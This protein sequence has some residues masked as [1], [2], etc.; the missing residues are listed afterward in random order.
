[1]LLPVPTVAES[2]YKFEYAS[3]MD[4]QNRGVDVSL[5]YTMPRSTGGF[6]WNSAFNIAYNT[7]ELKKLP[8]QLDAIVVGKNKLQVGER[9]DQY[10]LL[11][12]RGSYQSD[13]E[14]PVRD[15][16]NK[17]MTYNGTDMK[18]GDPRWVDQ[19]GN[20]DINNE[21]RILMGNIIPKWTGGFTN[22]FA[23]KNFDLS[24]LLYFNLGREIINQQASKKYDFANV[25]E[26]K[27]LYGVREITSWEKSFDETAYPIYNPWSSVVPYQAEQDLF[28]ED[29][30]FVKLKNLSVGY[31]LTKVVNNKKLNR[32]YVYVTG[33][34]LLTIT[35]Y[36]GRDPELVN[37][38]GY[39]TGTGIRYP[40]MYTLGVKLDF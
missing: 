15:G 13:A 36:S 9:I 30:S 27:N 6:C 4:V 31:D 17:V 5:N 26:S 23:Y 38:Y 24:F 3:G 22:Q 39:D 2:G 14:V 33:S 28:M 32:L 19:D 40:K 34:N 37:F 12:N 10:W 7:N 29:G 21:D 1:M 16:D 8:N 11:Q 20:F 25:A 18:G 35:K